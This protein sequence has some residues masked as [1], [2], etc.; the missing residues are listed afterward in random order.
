[1]SEG[2]RSPSTMYSTTMPNAKTPWLWNGS[3]ETN[4]YTPGTTMR[5]HEIRNSS[6]TKAPVQEGFI[7]RRTTTYPDAIKARSY[8]ALTYAHFTTITHAGRHPII[9]AAISL[10]VGQDLWF[11]FEAYAKVHVHTHGKE[12]FREKWLSSSEVLRLEILSR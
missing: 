5:L 8:C 2:K 6:G 12:A 4:K 7:K 10:T 3:D 11:A 1:M 9:I